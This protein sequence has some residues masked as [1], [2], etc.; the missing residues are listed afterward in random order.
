MTLKKQRPNPTMEHAN[1]LLAIECVNALFWNY[2]SDD[3]TRLKSEHKDFAH[4]WIYYIEGQ[5]GED[6]FNTL[7]NCWMT[8][9]NVATKNGIVAYALNKYAP[10]KREALESAYAMHKLMTSGR[11]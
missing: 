5:S 1:E 3:I 2:T 11:L 9:F 10:E 6:A 4:V 8:K 7:W